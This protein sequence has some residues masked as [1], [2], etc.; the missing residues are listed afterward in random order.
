MLQIKEDQI[1]YKSRRTKLSPCQWHIWHFT[2]ESLIYLEENHK[3]RKWTMWTLNQILSTRDDAPSAPCC[4]GLEFLT[5]FWMCPSMFT[6]LN[7]YQSKQSFDCWCILKLK[8]QWPR[9]HPSMLE[10]TS[11][12]QSTDPHLMLQDILLLCI[13]KLRSFPLS[14]HS[15]MSP[16]PSIWKQTSE[17][18][19][20][21]LFL[22]WSQTKLSLTILKLKLPEASPRNED[23][24]LPKQWTSPKD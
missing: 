2:I 10:N 20:K 16:R 21:S 6:M 23:S 7:Q 15:G 13:G 17:K 18:V 14:Q 1:P 24:K 11:E 12:L 4:P 19:L 3:W 22:D 8:L 9:D 5:T